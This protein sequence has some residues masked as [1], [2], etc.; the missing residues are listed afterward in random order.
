MEP[1]ENEKTWTRRTLASSCLPLFALGKSTSISSL[2]SLT[3]PRP[4]SP[5]LSSMSALAVPSGEQFQAH[6]VPSSPPESSMPASSSQNTDQTI[7]AWGPLKVA[8]AVHAATPGVLASQSAD[9]TGDTSASASLAIV[10]MQVDRNK[11]KVR[12]HPIQGRVAGRCPGHGA[13]TSCC[14]H[15]SDNLSSTLVLCPWTADGR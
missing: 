11:R 6:S 8:W 10:S 2:C 14:V 5:P 1:L 13:E 3:T 12:T 7:P 9:S 15:Q 4:P